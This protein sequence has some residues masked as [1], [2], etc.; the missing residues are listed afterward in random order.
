MNQSPKGPDRARVAAAVGGCLL[1][2]EALTFGAVT[3]VLASASAGLAQIGGRE[4]SFGDY[5]WLPPVLLGCLSVAALGIAA[6]AGARGVIRVAAWAAWMVALASIAAL[7][8]ADMQASSSP[9]RAWAGAALLVS[10]L[11][12][13]IAQ[14]RASRR[15]GDRT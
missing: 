8:R 13:T 5:W 9:P 11:L 6:A 12:L 10:P 14:R 7:L 4:L 1:A 2:A 3:A 15:V